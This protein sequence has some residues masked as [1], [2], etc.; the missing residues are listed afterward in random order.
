MQNDTLEGVAGFGM[1]SFLLGRENAFAGRKSDGKKAATKHVCVVREGGIRSMLAVE[2]GLDN[3]LLAVRVRKV[4]SRGSRLHQLQEHPH[5]RLE[6]H[7]VCVEAHIA[8]PIPSAGLCDEGLRCANEEAV[9]CF[10]KS[11]IR[12]DMQD[13]LVCYERPCNKLICSGA[14]RSKRR[15]CQHTGCKQQ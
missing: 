13:A 5:V 3:V 12:V 6:Q 9:R 10:V 11:H 2:E 1:G 14:T 8:L 15:I 4:L 7:Y